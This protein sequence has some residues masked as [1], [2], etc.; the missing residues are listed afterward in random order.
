MDPCTFMSSGFCCVLPVGSTN[1]R[2]EGRRKVQLIYLF[3]GSILTGSP[4][5]FSGPQLL[6][7]GSLCQYLSSNSGVYPFL[8]LSG[9]GILTDPYCCKLHPLLVFFNLAHTISPVPLLNCPQLLHLR[10]PSAS[11]WDPDQCNNLINH[12]KL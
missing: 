7:S 1:M 9:L 3:S 8:V 12:I 10:V 4:S 5:L 6:S 2:L 11:Y